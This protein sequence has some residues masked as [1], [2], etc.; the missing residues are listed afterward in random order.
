MVDGF[1]ST[2]R[3]YEAGGRRSACHSLAEIGELT[4][5]GQREAGRDCGLPT[6]REV[7]QDAGMDIVDV[8]DL[9]D[10]KGW[11]GRFG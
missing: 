1:L 7:R 2:W 11:G 8:V 6:A 5:D 10:V 9:R 3:S 4:G